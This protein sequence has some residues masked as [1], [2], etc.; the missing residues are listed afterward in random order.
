MCVH[1]VKVSD[2]FCY[3]VEKKTKQRQQ[4]N[5]GFVFFQN[6]LTDVEWSKKKNCHTF[7]GAL[8]GL[9]SWLTQN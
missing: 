6:D 3:F 2:S 4:A 5:L 8:N 9:C 7:L 1:G